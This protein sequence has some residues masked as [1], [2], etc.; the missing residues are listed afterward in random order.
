MSFTKSVY[1]VYDVVE[2]EKVV[3]AHYKREKDAL[4]AQDIL[5]AQY[6]AFE[7]LGYRLRTGETIELDVKEIKKYKLGN[8]IHQE[9]TIYDMISV[10][11][12]D[13]LDKKAAKFIGISLNRYNKRKKRLNIS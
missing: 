11:D 5:Q 12:V 6:E 8:M 2:G 3:Y 1:I 9:C 10:E 4:K 13:K 7:A